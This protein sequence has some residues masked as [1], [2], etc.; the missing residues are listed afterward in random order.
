M[1]AVEAGHPREI[2]DHYHRQVATSAALEGGRPGDIGQRRDPLYR[3][4]HASIHDEISTIIGPVTAQ[5]I[6]CHR[7]PKNV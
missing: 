3:I 4:Q 6:A 2:K 5:G 7:S 1:E